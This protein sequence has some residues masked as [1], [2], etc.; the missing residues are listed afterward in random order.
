[1]TEHDPPATPMP[2]RSAP[3]PEP[4]GPL[5]SAPAA[6]SPGPGR[7]RSL[8]IGGLWLLSLGG[9]W[10]WTAWQ[11]SGV[12]AERDRLDFGLRLEQATRLTLLGQRALD[13]ASFGEA[14]GLL[15]AAR[16]ASAR[17]HRRVEA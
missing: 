13:A 6:A 7:R 8:F 9:L 2:S 10:G 15:E 4:R 16:E 12:R 3:A 14:A 1:M 5:P 17:A 11:A